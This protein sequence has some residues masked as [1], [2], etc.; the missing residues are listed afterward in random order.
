MKNIYL[1][2][3]NLVDNANILLK[4]TPLGIV[5]KEGNIFKS[6]N[7]KYICNIASCRGLM[8]TGFS[9]EIKCIYPK[10]Y[11]EY[12]FIL[13]ST[14]ARRN[15]RGKY[16]IL[17]GGNIELANL[18]CIY[19]L[20]KKYNY[21]DYFA[22]KTATYKFAYFATCGWK[23]F[24][25]VAIPNHFYGTIDER[26]DKLIVDLFCEIAMENEKF[27]VEIWKNKNDY[28]TNN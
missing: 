16:L 9:K 8:S 5:F 14:E 10:V 11:N 4:E 19:P 28:F 17:D 27:Q 13:S 25:T 20:G 24:V 3:N 6:E 1:P 21:F 26:Q 15:L 7:A 2:V 12:R 18:F 23:K 22:L